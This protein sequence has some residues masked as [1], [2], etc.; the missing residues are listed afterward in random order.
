MG[1]EVDGAGDDLMKY[2]MSE[3]VSDMISLDRSVPDLRHPGCRHRHY[4]PVLPRATIVL[5]FHNEALSVL[6]RTVVSIIN[7]S[8]QHLIDEVLL[9][10]DHSDTVKHPQLGERLEQWVQEQSQVRLMRNKA[11]QGLIRSKNIGAE[12]SRGEVVVFLDAHCE[13]NTN[14]LPPLL[15]PIV[16]DKR[17]V[18]VPLV[19]KIDHTTFQYSSIYHHQ[20][21]HN[22]LND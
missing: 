7:R 10:D 5:V 13:V 14:W 22:H 12:E 15:A 16:E 19:D 17:T 4:P 20:V 11:R 2:G 8:P 3:R 9:V 21:D 6:L 18:S 1:V